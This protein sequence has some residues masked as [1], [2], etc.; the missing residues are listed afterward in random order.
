VQCRKIESLFVGG[1]K[2]GIKA[3]FIE[4]FPS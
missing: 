1:L 2:T 4:P 3:R